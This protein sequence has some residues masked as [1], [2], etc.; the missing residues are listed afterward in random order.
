MDLLQLLILIVIAGICGAVAE[1]I[2]GFKPGGLLVSIIVGVVGA[3]LGGWVGS[4]LPFD[5]VPWTTIVVNSVP[6]NLFWSTVGSI[7]LLALL[8]ILR[9]GSRRSVFGRRLF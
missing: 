3:Y 4:L 9:S 8:H 6:I 7:V 1:W 5:L 2:V